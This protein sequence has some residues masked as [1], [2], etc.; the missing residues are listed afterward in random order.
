[1][2]CVCVYLHRSFVSIKKMTKYGHMILD[3]CLSFSQILTMAPEQ[4]SGSQSIIFN[5]RLFNT[6]SVLLLHR[7]KDTMGHQLAYLPGPLVGG[8]CS[9][10]HSYST[11]AQ[12]RRNPQNNRYGSTSA[13]L[14]L[15]LNQAHPFHR[16][17]SR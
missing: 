3:L 9:G 8:H 6:D 13:Q 7:S 16:V 11:C 10:H 17:C 1:M 2:K 15:A 14:Y 4:L 5:D 12:V